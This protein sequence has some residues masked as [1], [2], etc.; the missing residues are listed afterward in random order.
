M[1][2]RFGTMGRMR[3][4]P[5]ALVLIVITAVWFFSASFRFLRDLGRSAILAFKGG[6][7]DAMADVDR[8]VATADLCALAVLADGE[9]TAQKMDGLGRALREARTDVSAQEALRRIQKTQNP[10]PFHEAVKRAAMSLA[11]PHRAPVLRLVA[12]LA[13]SGAG[14]AAAG[15]YRSGRRSDPKALVELYASALGVSE[16]ER[17][18]ALRGLG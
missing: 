3:V 5:Y 4:V 17:E 16:A 14:L 9:L 2:R 6:R 12:R 8:A 13:A 1:D 10:P 11:A 7:T 15:A 18:E